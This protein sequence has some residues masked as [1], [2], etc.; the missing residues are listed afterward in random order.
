[1]ATRHKK[2]DTREA[3]ISKKIYD[4]VLDEIVKTR[5]DLNPPMTREQLAKRLGFHPSNALRLENGE[6]L[7]DLSRFVEVCLILQVNPVEILQRAWDKVL[8]PKNKK[9]ETKT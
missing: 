1:M 5:K 6:Q 9:A 8:L 3:R 7:M 2:A 4:L